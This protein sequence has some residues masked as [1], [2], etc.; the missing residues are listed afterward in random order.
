MFG[1]SG[2]LKVTCKCTV[3]NMRTHN[4]CERNHLNTLIIKRI[5]MYILQSVHSLCNMSQRLPSA[6]FGSA[7]DLS[8]NIYLLCG[9]GY[10]CICT[11]KF[12][13]SYI[14]NG[15]NV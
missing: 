12:T 9:T 3:E 14:C 1:D 5:C 11:D 13:N 4:V 8:D 10:C 7:V 15:N 6:V 2:H